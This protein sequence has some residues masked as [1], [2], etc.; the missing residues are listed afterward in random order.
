MAD[1]TSGRS[2]SVAID[3]KATNLRNLTLCLSLGSPP[4]TLTVLW[5]FGEQVLCRRPK[6]QRDSSS[7]PA[8]WGYHSN[9]MLRKSRFIEGSEAS[10]SLPTEVI[11]NNSN[12]ALSVL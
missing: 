7:D 12:K 5:V 1:R 10:K 9:R 8:Y 11:M 6:H 2:A 4:V 3:Y